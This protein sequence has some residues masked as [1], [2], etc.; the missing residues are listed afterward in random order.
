MLPT[1]LRSSVESATRA[2]KASLRALSSEEGWRHWLRLLLY[3]RFEGGGWLVDAP[4]KAAARSDE[5]YPALCPTQQAELARLLTA[6]P[7]QVRAY[8]ELLGW[9]YQ[10]WQRENKDHLQ[11]RG[12]R[13]TPA[14]VPAVTQLFTDNALVDALLEPLLPRPNDTDARPLIPVPL[15]TSSAAKASC[16]SPATP[17]SFR[18]LDPCCGAGHV[19]LEALRRLVLA[20]QQEKNW[21]VGQ[22]VPYVLEHMIFGLELDPVCAEVASL[23][24]ALEAR[25]LLVGDPDGWNACLQQPSPVAC[26][27]SDA[28]ASPNEASSAMDDLYLS[29]APT[30]GSLLATHHLRPPQRKTLRTLQHT[31]NSTHDTTQSPKQT[32]THF[33]QRPR[34]PLTLPASLETAMETLERRYDAV[35]TNVP[36][37]ARGKQSAMLRD[38]CDA[39]YASSRHDLANVFLERCLELAKPE[40]GEVHVLMPQNWLFLTSY[41]QQRRRLLKQTRWSRLRY[42]GEGV[43]ESSGAAGAFPILLSLHNH[44]PRDGDHLTIERTLEKANA[45]AELE[46]Q[47]REQASFLVDADAR[48]TWDKPDRSLPPLSDFADAFVG[49]QTGDDPR[50]LRA[51]WELPHPPDPRW[52]PLHGTPTDFARDDGDSWLVDWRGGCGPLH[53]STGAR[54][55]QG[56]QA[57]GK[58]GVA[59]HRMR[60]IFAYNYSGH[61][62]HQNIAVIV[63]KRTEDFAAIQAFCHAPAFEA[64]VRQLDQKL[65][66][67]NRTLTAVPFD[68]DAWAAKANAQNCGMEAPLNA[69]PHPFRQRSFRGV[70]DGPQAAEVVLARLLGF[71]WPTEA[72]LASNIQPPWYLCVHETAA[73]SREEDLVRFQR[74]LQQQAPASELAKASLER[75]RAWLR[76]EFFEQ[77]CRSFLDRPFLWQIWDGEPDGFSVIL[78]CHALDR[79]GLRTLIDEPLTTWL[80]QLHS[81]AHLPHADITRLIQAG[82][83]LRARLEAIYLGESPHDVFVRWKPLEAQPIGWDPDWNDGLRLLMRP[84]LASPAGTGSRQSLLRVSPRLHFRPDRGNDGERSHWPQLGVE[85]GGR[86][87][88]RINDHHL[89]LAEKRAASTRAVDEA[90][91]RAR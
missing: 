11:R 42:L 37:L 51:F 72:P 3:Y 43:F 56:Q 7:P 68:R 86:A 58:A 63:P 18:L 34:A 26:F 32:T 57:W 4:A 71:R 81:A 76:N 53:Q 36:F 17:S 8:P 75:L 25:R 78:R 1:P 64:A 91:T 31:H 85:A 14:Q 38:F 48:I 41:R 61:R 28:D 2:A 45:T 66:V 5:S 70:P 35:V 22:A 90:R 29:L 88:D 67:T 82:E 77:H 12:A 15:R 69:N 73:P 6:L 23:T 59:V 27:L 13:I 87:G 54:P 19:L 21:T 83:Q 62:F 40:R 24:L 10:A 47:T 89:R 39:F 79:V 49:L 65:N 52:K 46:R 16:V 84:F 74:A 9:A 33:G 60:R 50:Y 20:L 44:L 55:D 30:L 80:H